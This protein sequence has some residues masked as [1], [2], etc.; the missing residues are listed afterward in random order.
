MDLF[1]KCTEHV[2]KCMRDANKIDASSVHDV[3]LVGGS[4]QIPKV[5]Q[6]LQDW[7]NKKELCK[8]INPDEAVAYG[9]AVQAA[10]LTSEGNQKVQALSLS[11][12][13]FSSS[14]QESTEN[15]WPVLNVYIKNGV[16]SSMTL[17]WK[18]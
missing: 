15:V 7:F 10:I 9:A 17:T 18:G 16:F 6:L 14:Y 5:Q 3:V 4:T 8:S 12:T 1:R 2:G 11:Q 13:E